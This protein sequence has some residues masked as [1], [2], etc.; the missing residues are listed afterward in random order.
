MKNLINTVMFTTTILLS[1]LVSGCVLSSNQEGEMIL[2]PVEFVSA[3]TYND[4]G[5]VVLYMRPFDNEI[6]NEEIVFIKS[7]LLEY[8]PQ[9]YYDPDGVLKAVD[10]LPTFPVGSKL[11]AFGYAI[12]NDRISNSYYGSIGNATD[13][14]PVYEKAQEWFINELAR[15]NWGRMDKTD[16]KVR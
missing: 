11:V 5:L 1:C 16:T 15:S 13:I 14:S 9:F 10:P 8:Y 7:E 2:P 3:K 4:N 6:T 12:Y